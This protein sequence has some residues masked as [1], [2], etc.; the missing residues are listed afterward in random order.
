MRARVSCAILRNVGIR[1]PCGTHLLGEVTACFGRV[2]SVLV[3]EV[4]NSLN[5][6]LTALLAV[7][8]SWEESISQHSFKTVWRG[9][10]HVGCRTCAECHFF[11][12]LLA[13]IDIVDQLW[14]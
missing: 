11:E 5:G 7:A 2:V 8:Y 13:T 6:D 9:V 14:G 12:A 10:E 4:L 1:C 3:D